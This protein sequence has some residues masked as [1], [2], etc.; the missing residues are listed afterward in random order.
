MSCYSFKPSGENTP[1]TNEDKEYAA[2]GFEFEF[3][4]DAPPVRYLRFYVHE[5][6][7][8]AANIHISELSFF[9]GKVVEE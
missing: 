1:I 2:N 5:T 7:G 3:P 4:L 6:W 9:W 8:G